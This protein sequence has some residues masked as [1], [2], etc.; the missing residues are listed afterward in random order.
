MGEIIEFYNKD[1]KEAYIDKRREGGS[2][3]S[4]KDNV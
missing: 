4:L 2:N 3:P 1:Y